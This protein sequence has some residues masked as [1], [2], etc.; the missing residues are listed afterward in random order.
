MSFPLTSPPGIYM[1]EIITQTI[2]VGG[3]TITL[4]T[5][6]LAQKAHGA[7]LA[8]MGDTAVLATVVASDPVEGLDYF[9]LK[10]DYE[11]RLYAG[12]IIKGSRWVKR[13]GRPSEDSVLTARVID[14]SIRPLF[15]KTYRDDVQ[16]IAMLMSV[17]NENDPVV[18]A[19]TAVSAAL[20][21]SGIP[22]N[23]PVSGVRIG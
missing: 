10:V 20:S 4:E 2:E 19:L 8:R 12:G 7:V 5:G 11:E 22:W 13:E 3:K 1:A 6:L 9:P 23:G 18:L 14:R 16:V 15:P 21:M 17:D